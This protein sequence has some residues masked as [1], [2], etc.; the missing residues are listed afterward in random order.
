MR[1]VLAQFWTKPQFFEALGSQIEWMPTSAA[2]VLE[3][4]AGGFGELL[5]VT[6][7]STNPVEYRLRQQDRLAQLSTRGRHIMASNSGHWIPLD[8]PEV[9]TDA[10]KEVLS[11]VRS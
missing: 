5:L 7:S 2:E 6:L 10:V 9:V 8:Q 4:T 3:A 1:P 11:A